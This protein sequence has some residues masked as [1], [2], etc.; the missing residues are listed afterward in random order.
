M[1]A[2]VEHS[3]GNGEQQRCNDS[4]GK[5][6]QNCPRN[7]EH[8]CRSQTKQYET[9]VAYA[10]ITNDELEVMLAQRH[11]CR[12]NNSDHGQDG[13]P[14]APHLESFGKEIHR[15]AQARVS[16]KFHHDAGEQHRACRG[17]C[18]MTCRRPGMQRPDA[19]KH[20]EPEEQHRKSPRL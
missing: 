9:H 13:D 19:G 12:V 4:M 1:S 5:H 10:R 18:D 2:P 17:R 7:T 14:F 20:C 15:Y 3:S 16:T 6:L 8:V 11:R